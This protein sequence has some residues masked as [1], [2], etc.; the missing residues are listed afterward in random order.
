MP[1]HPFFAFEPEHIP[2]TDLS[3][4]FDHLWPEV[5]L[6]ALQS[7][8][9]LKFWLTL[10]MLG[11]RAPRICV[12]GSEITPPKVPQRG[13][14]Q[15]DSIS[16]FGLSACIGPWSAKVNFIRPFTGTWAYMDDRTM[17]VSALGNKLNLQA[18][19]DCVE[20]F[21]NAVGFEVNPDRTQIWSVSD[22]QDAQI[23]MENLGLK[24]SPAKN[25]SPVEARDSQKLDMCV[26]KDSLVVLDPSALGVV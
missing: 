19:L 9:A 6:T 8:G 15:G 23:K 24:Y 10:T 20:N 3:K 16:P 1:L 21:D 4:A 11:G 14:P 22:P 12:V 17:G 18:A 7:L 2:E 25:T 5:A 26:S 13:S